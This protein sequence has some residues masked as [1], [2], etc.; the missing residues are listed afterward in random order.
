MYTDNKSLIQ[1]F[2]QIDK[3]VLRNG[4]DGQRFYSRAFL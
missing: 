4:G 3:V 1:T 2:I